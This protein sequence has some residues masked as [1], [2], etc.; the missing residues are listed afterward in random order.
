[1]PST[2]IAPSSPWC[3]G[4]VTP[5]HNIEVSTERRRNIQRQN[6]DRHLRLEAADRE[7]DTLH[8][9]RSRTRGDA[10]CRALAPRG[11]VKADAIGE[12]PGNDGRAGSGVQQHL[13]LRLGECSANE[14]QSV[15]EDLD[16][17]L[18]TRP[19]RRTGAGA[20]RERYG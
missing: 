2:P 7:G 8:L 17:N 4:T 12:R 11:G 18:L 5:E 1:M 6:H 20:G 16:L 15:S 9:D 19:L 14:H 10:Q 13:R 3:I